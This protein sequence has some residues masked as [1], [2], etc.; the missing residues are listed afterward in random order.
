MLDMRS[1]RRRVAC[2]MIRPTLAR[3]KQAIGTRIKNIRVNCQLIKQ[4]M[5]TQ[6][7]ARSG[8]ATTLPNSVLMPV[9]KRFHVVGEAGHQLAGALVAELVDIEMDDVAIEAIAQVEQRQ[10]DDAAN[11]RLLGEFK[12]A[13][14][15]DAADD[16][17]DHPGQGAEAIGRQESVDVLARHLIPV[18]AA[19][20]RAELGLP[21]GDVAIDVADFLFDVAIGGLALF[22]H[23]L[24]VEFLKLVLVVGDLPLDL[25]NPRIHPLM[26]ALLGVQQFE[27]GIDGGEVGPP[28]D[29]GAKGTEDGERDAAAVRPSMTESAEEIFHGTHESGARRIGERS[30]AARFRVLAQGAVPDKGESRPPPGRSRIVA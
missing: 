20:R 6:A 1:S 13:F 23:L 19:G 12:E 2:F 22:Q 30:I 11:Q 8:S 17:E 15:D 27:D 14:D 24:P 18:Q 7:R 21:F 25:A 10:I 9:P 26:R 4:A 29:G 28:Q 3:M 5:M 16:Q